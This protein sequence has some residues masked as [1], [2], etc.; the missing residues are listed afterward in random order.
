MVT[1]EKLITKINGQG[2]CQVDKLDQYRPQCYQFAYGRLVGG[3][4]HNQMTLVDHHPIQL[5]RL[6]EFVEVL[7]KGSLTRMFYTHKH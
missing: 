7:E 2:S 5:M 1:L 6:V 4:S 3:H